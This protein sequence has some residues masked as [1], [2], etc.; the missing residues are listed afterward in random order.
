MALTRQVF[1]QVRDLIYREILEYHPHMLAD[2][3]AG[4]KQQASFMYPSAV[5]NFK[6]Q[7]A[8]LEAGGAGA[9]LGANANLGQAR[10]PALSPASLAAMWA[11]GVHLQ[12]VDYTHRRGPAPTNNSR[13]CR[14]AATCAAM[15]QWAKE[16]RGASCSFWGSSLEAH[17]CYAYRQN[18]ISGSL[19]RLSPQPQSSLVPAKH[20]STAAHASSHHLLCICSAANGSAAS[21][22]HLAG[23]VGGTLLGVLAF[24]KQARAWCPVAS[25]TRMFGAVMGAGGPGNESAAR[26]RE[27]VPERGAAL[28][29]ARRGTPGMGQDRG[30]RSSGQHRQ[31]CQQNERG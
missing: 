9:R 28:R 22:C 29:G 5:D 27:G 18:S 21:S 31:R 20:S 3:L 23:S 4:G 10:H 1:L 19:A 16:D 7:F 17:K 13:W 15:G 6:R 25:V 12:P 24:C 2:Y 14:V 11:L 26:A 8:H 30:S